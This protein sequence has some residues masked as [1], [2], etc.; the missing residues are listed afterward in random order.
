MLYK[1]Y[2]LFKTS[3]FIEWSYKLNNLLRIGNL[4]FYTGIF[5]FLGGF[6]DQAQPAALHPY[7]GKYFSFVLVGL[8]ISWYSTEAQNTFAANLREQQ[9]LGT[10][11]PLVATGT[12]LFTLL[13]GLAIFDFF[14]TTLQVLVIVLVAVLFMGLQVAWAKLV[15]A[16]SILLISIAAFWGLGVISA[17]FVLVFKKGDPLSWIL[18]N[19]S[20]LI[21]GVYYP[22]ESLP[23]FG[24]N[25]AA[26]LPITYALKATRAVLLQSASLY[27]V[28]NE[29]LILAT[30]AVAILLI[31][32]FILQYALKRVTR[33]GSLVG[34]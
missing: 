24:Q 14:L 32:Y 19:V 8:I 13:S 16:L 18:G 26:V 12:G 11:E 30:F 2:W 10:L 9:V 3:F 23:Q 17:A 21:G 4:L 20:A 29:I 22:V 15:A 33:E 6:I 27:Q 5:Y 1:L 28:R 25:L 34:Y 7:G 31:S